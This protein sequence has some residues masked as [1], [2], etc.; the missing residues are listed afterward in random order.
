MKKFLRWLGFG[1]TR[2]A[3][4]RLLAEH[5]K[6]KQEHEIQQRCNAKLGQALE[7]VAPAKRRL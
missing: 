7:R 1:K 6:L 3:Y 5:S 2:I 4:E